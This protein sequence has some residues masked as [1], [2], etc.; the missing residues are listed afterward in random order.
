MHFRR[1][2]FIIVFSLVFHSTSLLFAQSAAAGGGSPVAALTAEIVQARD[3]TAEYV[4]L[5]KHDFA[6]KP[7]ELTQARKL[8]ADAYGKNNKWV[9][10]VKVSLR[11]GKGK[12]L[13]EDPAY[14]KIA[15]EASASATEFVKYV[16]S[17]T[18]H[19]VALP[20]V[21]TSFFDLGLK[22]WNAIKDG[23]DKTRN[24]QAD[25]FEKDT[26]W[27]AWDQIGKEPSSTTPDAKPDPSKKKN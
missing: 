13:N 18:R 24:T 22:L 12:K 11:E 25:A 7:E 15:E 27:Q 8:Y 19:S 16:D 23:R 3:T 20:S 14:K 10:Y 1:F 26:K 17:K 2:A 6:Q 4:S 5:A 21:L 9:A